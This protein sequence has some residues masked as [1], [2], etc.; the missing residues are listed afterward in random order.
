MRFELLKMEDICMKKVFSFLLLG[1][2]I[3]GYSYAQNSN[4]APRV[5]GTWVEDK[6]NEFF[7]GI[8]L[9]IVGN[10]AVLHVVDRNGYC[11]DFAD[12]SG[13]IARGTISINGDQISG[14]VSHM[15]GNFFNN[16]GGYWKEVKEWAKEVY[17]EDE[18]DDYHSDAEIV[19]VQYTA[20]IQG[21]KMSVYSEFIGD[22]ITFT[23]Q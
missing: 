23:K 15:W 16:G 12:A 7:L 11:A 1:M 6:N 14:F 20:T 3:L 2:V 8:A 21:N 18:Y 10:S 19:F 4:A 13:N 5:G 22:I 17:Y 9:T